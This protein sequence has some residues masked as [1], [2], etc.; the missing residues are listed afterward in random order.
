VTGAVEI[1]LGRELAVG[2]RG[3]EDH[4]D[5]KKEATTTS[6]DDGSHCLE[7]A[8]IL[9]RK[10]KFILP[11]LVE[12]GGTGSGDRTQ[13]PT[14]MSKPN[15]LTTTTT[16]PRPRRDQHIRLHRLTQNPSP[17]GRRPSL[18]SI[19]PNQPLPLRPCRHRLNPTSQ[20]SPL[21]SSR[22]PT[23]PTRNAVPT[24]PSLSA[25]HSQTAT[26]APCTSSTANR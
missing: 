21:T 25:E 14:P 4:G 6:V 1:Q 2:E 17:G 15:H 13:S 8:L 22:H 5:D 9:T 20:N 12:D 3:D 11:M 26:S 16:L 7:R 10:C 23:P 18:Q 19:P 24:L